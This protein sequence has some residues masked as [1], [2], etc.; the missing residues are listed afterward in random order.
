M[1]NSYKQF[2]LVSTL[3]ASLLFSNIANAEAR[4]ATLDARS[5]LLGSVSA[6][7]FQS[8]LEQEFSGDQAS[9]Q[10]LGKELQGLQEKAQRDGAVMS[11]PEKLKLQ[12]QMVEKQDDAKF[13]VAKL[14]KASNARQQE[15]LRSMQPKLNE[16]I[17]SVVEADQIDILLQNQALAFAK[18]T[19]DITAKVTAALDQQ[20]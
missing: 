1:H 10:S 12:Q 14:R 15:W 7:E 4:I 2:V 18:P 8:S 20:K 5:A 17:T 11:E 13:Q 6:K 19:F 16:A 3:F 9:I